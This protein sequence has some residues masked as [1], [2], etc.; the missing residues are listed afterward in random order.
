VGDTSAVHGVANGAVLPFQTIAS[1][2]AAV[3]VEA[4]AMATTMLIQALAR[5]T[6]ILFVI[7]PS[8]TRFFVESRVVHAA[9]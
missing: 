7:R 9:P 2:G 3:A 6:A 8:L 1:S 4:M 5:L